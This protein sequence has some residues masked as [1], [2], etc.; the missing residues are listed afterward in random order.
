[1]PIALNISKTQP[2]HV[3]FDDDPTVFPEIFNKDINFCVWKRNI[4][5]LVKNY[6]EQIAKN[7][8]NF[9][10]LRV[11][12]LDQLRHGLQGELPYFDGKEEFIQDTLF[13]SDMFLELFDLKELGMRLTVLTNA[14]C[15]KFHVDR[16]P[17]RLIT[18]YHGKATEWSPRTNVAKDV[19]NRLVI[20]DENLTEQI[21][22]ADVALLKG[23]GWYNNE[24]KGI[25]HRSPVADESNPRLVL[26]L[27]FI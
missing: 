15:P 26:T 25:T 14:M 10:F 19:D 18:T 17:C 23:E 8:Q 1:M 4:E 16:V 7:K 12:D 21:E 11:G 27:D 24:G 20:I 2:H 3:C 22:T 6:A 5:P 13:T 9:T